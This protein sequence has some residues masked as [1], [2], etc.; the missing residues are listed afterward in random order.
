MRSE[1]ERQG[2]RVVQTYGMSETCGGCVYDGWPL[3]GVEVRIEDGQVLLRGP[4]LFDGYLGE[5]ERTGGRSTTAGSTPTTSA[6][7]TTTAVSGCSAA[8]DDVIISGGVKVPAPA[9][10]AA[11]AADQ[12]V[13]AVEVLGVPDEE[14]GERV[15]AFVAPNDP[16]TLAG[17]RDLVEPR[18]WAPRQL[19]L[20]EEIPLLPNGKLDR[21]RLRELA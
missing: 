15:V 11:I 16:L 18:T 17:L 5:P 6:R 20:V 3:D 9:V 12:A 7:S 10:A 8:G 21:V 1:A 2:I 4:M 14:W 13:R 19:V